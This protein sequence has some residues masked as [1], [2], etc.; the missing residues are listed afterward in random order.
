M[1][2]CI[3]YFFQT[4][5]CRRKI[6]KKI[7]YMQ[8]FCIK[9]CVID[10]YFISLQAQDTTKS[11]ITMRRPICC[12]ALLMATTLS[13]RTTLYVDDNTTNFPNPER[14]FFYGAG[15]EMTDTTTVS[16]LSDGQ[17]SADPAHSLI[18]MEYN[19]S[20]FRHDSLSPVTLHLMAADF[21]KMR[22]HGYKCILR[23]CYTWTDDLI[24]GKIPDGSPAIWKMHLEQLKPVLH[25]N[26]DVIACVQAGFLGIW[27]EWA[28]TSVKRDSLTIARN[29][30]IDQLLEA[31]PVTRTIQVRTPAYKQTYLGDTA[32]LSSEEA[33]TGTPKAR[34]SHHNDAFLY[35]STNMGTYQNRKRDMDYLSRECLYLPNGGESDVY[36]QP[37]YDKWATGDKAKEE[38]AY[39]HYSFL[40]QGYAQLVISNWRNEGVFEEL[41]RNIGYRF[42]LL[43]STIPA[44]AAKGAMLPISLEIRNAGYACLYNERKAYIVLRSQDTTMS[45]VS[46]TDPRRWLPNGAITHIHDTIAL[47]ADMPDGTYDICLWMPD[48]DPK[49]HLDPRYAIRL[50][51]DRVWESETGY[52]NLRTTVEVSANPGPEPP[53]PDPVP[54]SHVQAATQLTGAAG[55]TFASLKWTNPPFGIITR[56]QTVDISQGTVHAFSPETGATTTSVTYQDGLCH[57]TYTTTDNWLWAGV[58][59]PVSGFE[60]GSRV[61]CEYLGD[62]KNTTMVAYVWDGENRWSGAPYAYSLANR[63]WLRDAYIPQGVLWAPTPTYAFG[64]RPVTH[65]CYVANPATPLSGSFDIRSVRVLKDEEIPSDFAGVILVRKQGAYPTSPNDG[66]MVYYGRDSVCIDYGV[67]Y[68]QTYYYAVFAFNQQDEIAYPATCIV[69]INGS[70]LEPVGSTTPPATAKYLKNG[71]IILI[72]QGQAYDL[73]G[74]KQ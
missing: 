43:K 56:S 44:T 52:N 48:I 32:A 37:V 60:P 59:F 65:V 27:G 61:E 20:G 23:Y 58:M 51:T 69:T 41:S 19:L 47:P 40:N 17:F 5:K 14:G 9:T 10:E 57:I 38:M 8:V 25:D 36:N 70:D 30:L 73:L 67:E 62:G 3:R 55:N 21:A 28:F 63:T 1:P 33:F 29:N 42:Q 11:D 54:Q 31:V 72:R 45:F 7:R 35:E 2:N 49:I 74:N 18:H 71:E 53:V 13:A 26:A 34:L 6:T 46:N 66:D 16:P 22:A 15:Y 39:L 68:G 12:I 24:E 4:L 64:E 50:A